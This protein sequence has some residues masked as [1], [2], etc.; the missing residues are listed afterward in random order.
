MTTTRATS[1]VLE[2][3]PT[4]PAIRITT[5]GVRRTGIAVAFGSLVWAA[6]FVIFGPI[7]D[8]PLGAAGGDLGGLV[9]QLGLF[10]LLAVQERTLATGP[11]R[12]WR[13]AFIVERVLLA[14]AATWSLLHAFWPDLAFLP[15]LDLFWPL[16][17]V[18]M[19]VI[20][21]AILVKGRWSGPLRIWPAI[22]ESWAVV[23]VPALAVI[24]PSVSVWLPA[25]HLLLGYITLGILLAV[26]P[27]R[28]GAAAPVR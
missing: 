14:I 9:F 15:I 25:T 28:T 26:V 12:F 11:K 1:S 23:C 16:S 24:G 8:T 22:A 13:V 21:V 4:A 19:F 10:A 17:M 27:E 6:S 20:G 3:P 18:G 2:P 7:A 5:K